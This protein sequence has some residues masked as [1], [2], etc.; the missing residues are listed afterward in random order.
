MQRSLLFVSSCM[1][2]RLSDFKT[3]IKMEKLNT[4]ENYILL[5][6]LNEKKNKL[7]TSLKRVKNYDTENKICIEISKIDELICK[8]ELI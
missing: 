4:E 3:Q 7:K 2:R 6:A 5:N 8:L 1:V